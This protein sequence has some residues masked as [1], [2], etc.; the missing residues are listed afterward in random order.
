MKKLMILAGLLAVAATGC[1]SRAPVPPMDTRVTIAEDLTDDIYVTD[2]RCTKGNSDFLTF[3][4]NLVNNLHSPLA[5]EWKV[6]WL[7]A[8]GLEIESYV[9]TWNALVIQPNEIRGL[10]GT[11]PKSDAADMRFYARRAKR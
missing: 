5:V 3:Q 11:A 4:A 9:S 7:D 10:K 1:I 6:Q 8:D 2:V